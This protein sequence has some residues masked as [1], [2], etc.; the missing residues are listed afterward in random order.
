MSNPAF[1]CLSR[2][3]GRR[4]EPPSAGRPWPRTP[5]ERLHISIAN[6][7]SSAI[8]LTAIFGALTTF[9]PFERATTMKLDVLPGTTVGGVLRVSVNYCVGS[10][11]LVRLSVVLKNDITVV[12]TDELLQ[13]PEGCRVT[14]VPFKLSREV[15]A[16]NYR[17]QI[18]GVVQPW[19]WRSVPY[20]FESRP[21]EIHQVPNVQ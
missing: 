20:T 19:P 15:P 7:A 14:Q 13:L 3:L 16:G 17:L 18:Y 2:W 1:D 6:L 5:Y 12:L 11:P 4:C 10:S 21:F 8:L 9:V